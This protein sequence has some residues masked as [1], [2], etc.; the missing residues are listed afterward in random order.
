MKYDIILEMHFLF[1]IKQ[2]NNV[3]VGVFRLYIILFVTITLS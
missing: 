3:V 1:T 2:Y